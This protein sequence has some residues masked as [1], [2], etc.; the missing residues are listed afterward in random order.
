MVNV[1]VPENFVDTQDVSLENL[2]DSL[3]YTQ[4]TDVN[5]SIDSNLE[6]NQRTDDQIDNV[7]SLRM[8]SIEGNMVVTNPEWAALL[9]LTVDVNGIRPVKVWKVNWTDATGITV[10]TAFN[11]QLQTLTPVDI[12]LGTFTLFFRTQSNE[13]AGIV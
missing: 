11:G 7:F 3:T 1:G 4:L 6:K 12:G 13:T 9:A 10:S 5:F 8:I 2:S